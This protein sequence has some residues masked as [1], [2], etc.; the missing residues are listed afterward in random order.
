MIIALLAALV[1]WL[2]PLSIPLSAGMLFLMPYEEAAYAAFCREA[3]GAAVVPD[4]ALPES[5]TDRF[6]M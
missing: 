2:I 1:I 3:S 6:D 4:P 5:G